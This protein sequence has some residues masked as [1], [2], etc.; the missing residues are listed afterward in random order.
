MYLK[1]REI[2]RRI[3]YIKIPQRAQG[4]QALSTLK[5]RGIVI[6]EVL[7]GESD[8]ILT[9]FAKGLGKISVRA[10][11]AK[12]VKSKFLAGTQ[13][14]TYSDFVIYT[15]LKYY[16]LA[17]VQIIESF[18]G[19]TKDYDKFYLGTDLLKLTERVI[20]ENLENDNILLLLLKALQVIC[21]EDINNSIVARAFELK[22]LQ[23]L[24]VAPQ[25]EGIYVVGSDSLKV[26]DGVRTAMEYVFSQPIN[27]NLFLF[28]LGTK[29][30]EELGQVNKFFIEGI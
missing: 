13:L 30:L 2:L 10:K 23:L 6:R 19:L 16:N 28:Q 21:K 9:I 7:V 29:E 1:I 18:Y 5:A 11:G 22:L 26:S 25:I 8:K 27:K 14:F 20:V 3:F 15:K 24:G 17:Q 4:R 12:N